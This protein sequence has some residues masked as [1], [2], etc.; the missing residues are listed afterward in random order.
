[1]IHS[2]GKHLSPHTC[3]EVHIMAL[4]S[5]IFLCVVVQQNNIFTQFY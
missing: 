2:S 3:S 5:L 4:M 1:M